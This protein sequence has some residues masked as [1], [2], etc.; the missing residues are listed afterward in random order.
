MSFIPLTTAGFGKKAPAPLYENPFPL[1]DTDWQYIVYGGWL[2]SLLALFALSSRALPRRPMVNVV[3]V[4]CGMPKK[5]MGWY[6]LVQLLRMPQARVIDVVEPFFLGVCKDVPE[7]FT[8]F[9]ASLQTQGVKFH[10]SLDDMEELPPRTMV[11]ISARTQ[12][13]PSHFATAL[14]K[15]AKCIYLEKVRHSGSRSDDL[16]RHIWESSV[17]RAL[18]FV[19]DISTTNSKNR[20]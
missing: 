15:G 14:D 19:R 11:L 3:L 4:G 2:V 13:N 16:R 17:G 5:S 12:D 18:E 8:S 20:Y 9:M 7:R 1:S 10:K 6:H